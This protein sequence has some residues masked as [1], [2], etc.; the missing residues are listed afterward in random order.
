MLLVAIVAVYITI[1]SANG[2]VGLFLSFI[3]GLAM[4]RVERVTRA[5]RRRELEIDATDYL[6]CF[7][8]SL[9]IW[10]IAISFG[11]AVFVAGIAGTWQLMLRTNDYAMKWT[12]VVL[13]G[14]LGIGSTIFVMTR[15]WRERI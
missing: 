3:S 5:Q 6:V 9:A 14:I 8:V 10:I 1:F 7:L 4:V 2:G 13:C 12:I 15:T 11:A